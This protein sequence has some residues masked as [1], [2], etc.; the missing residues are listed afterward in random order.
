MTRDS[1]TEFAEFVC[2][3]SREFPTVPGLP[4]LLVELCRLAKRHGKMMEDACNYEVP[5]NY[6]AAVE[7]RIGKVCAS[8]GCTPVFSGDPRGATVKVQVPSGRTNDW[9]ATG[10][11]VPQ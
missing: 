4:A 11:C 8:I 5:E 2:L 3:M 1:M 9:G 6:G 10:V 7:K